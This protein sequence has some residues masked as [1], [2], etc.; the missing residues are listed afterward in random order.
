MKIK[1]ICGTCG[2][3]SEKEF[4]EINRQI[5]QGR[6]TFFCD[7]HCAAEYNNKNRRAEV[8]NK[9]CPVCKNVF[10]TSLNRYEK[11]FCS[12][13]C[14]SKGSM[15]EER[16][17][18]QS[19]GGIKSQE[20]FPADIFEIQRIL[21]I[22]EAWKY[23]ALKSFFEEHKIEHDFESIVGNY[24]FDLLLFD[25]KI[26]IEFDGPYHNGKQK[27]TDSKKTEEAENLG[28]KVFRI[29]TNPNQIIPVESVMK[30]I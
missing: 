16:R 1:I 3:T 6:K 14:A 28:W 27:V 8:V 11:D 26:L 20:K 30:I 7:L 4:G 19:L 25:K 22:R 18:A 2:K 29:I 23:T 12:R 10:Q 5:R 15:S 9:I 17:L 21:K 24:I 13:G